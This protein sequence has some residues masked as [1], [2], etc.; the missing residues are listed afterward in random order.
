M[1]AI[2]R[3]EVRDGTVTFEGVDLI[4]LN[5]SNENI[6]DH[7]L[8]TKTLS[9]GART[10]QHFFE[11]V[12]SFDEDIEELSDINNHTMT[13]NCA[14]LTVEEFDMK[15]L[16]E[17]YEQIHSS[18]SASNSSNFV[19]NL[20]I[21]DEGMLAIASEDFELENNNI[22]L[23]KEVDISQENFPFEKTFASSRSKNINFSIA[24]L[25]YCA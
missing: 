3:I 17:Y 2:K 24:T 13:R 21:I 5:S 10:R 15:P 11:S 19:E 9:L 12:V 14:K 18:L 8:V 25:M 7:E 23:D 6:V 16:E 4:H 22:R 20:N 1:H